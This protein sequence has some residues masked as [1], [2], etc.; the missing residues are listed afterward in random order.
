V[1]KKA[2][3]NKIKM[4]PVILQHLRDIVYKMYAAKEH[5]TIDS[6]KIRFSQEVPEFKCCLRSINTWLHKIGFKFKKRGNR[7]F[8]TE[9]PSIRHK[10]TSFLRKYVTEKA[11]NNYKPVFIDET[12]V[13]SKGGNRNAWQDGTLQTESKKTG[14]GVRY[15][16]VHAGN[17]NGFVENAGLIFNSKSKKGDYHDNMNVENFQNWFK[18]QL[19]PNLEEPSLIIMDNASYHSQL[20]EPIPC[21][22]ARPLSRHSS[23]QHGR[24]GQHIL[25]SL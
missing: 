18:T 1:A 17:E 8:L 21:K 16:V 7:K 9:L 4:T 22:G 24:R 3:E 20:G 15:I 14:D 19:I 2:K 12:W 23:A 10:R 13:F 5:V 25:T 11:E 6:I